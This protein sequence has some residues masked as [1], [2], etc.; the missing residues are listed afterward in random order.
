MQN[1]FPHQKMKES[2][3]IDKYLDF[4]TELKKLWNLTVTMMPIVVG[5]FGTVPKL[6]E[7]RLEELEIRERLKTITLL[8]SARILKRRL[9]F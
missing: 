8:R 5:V 1:I 7:R 3:K 9:E 2:E 6:L 4:S